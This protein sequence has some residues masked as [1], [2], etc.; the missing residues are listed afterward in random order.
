MK[1]LKKIV[2]VLLTVMIVF[3][4][5]AVIP[6]ASAKTVKK[7]KKPAKFSAKLKSSS[8]LL[9]Y[10]TYVQLSWKK[11]KNAKKYEIYRAK[12]NAKG[13]GSYK[14]LKAV[15]KVKYNDVSINS[16]TYYKYKVR[17][18]NGKVKSKFTA[19]SKKLGY[20]NTPT[21]AVDMNEKCDAIE[22]QWFKIGGATGYK[23]YKST[24]KGKS[25][26]LLKNSKS[27]KE[28][29]GVYTYTDTSVKIGEH[30]YYYITA[31][32]SVMTSKK[33][34]VYRKVFKDY[35]FAVQAGDTTSVNILSVLVAYGDF[36]VESEDES[37]ATCKISEK[38]SGEKELLL[39]GV[40]E[41]YT[42]LK[43]KS[44]QT[45]ANVGRVKVKVTNEPVYDFT[46]KKGES[47]EVY[48]FDSIKSII[49]MYK[50]MGMKIK[51]KISAVSN[52]PEIAKITNP[53]SLNFKIVGVSE[54]E[55]LVKVKLS[56][57]IE[58]NT[59]D[60]LTAKYMVKVE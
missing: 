55:V 23:I 11:V 27:F 18:V 57:E 29:D 58:G 60:V 40:K 17:A 5:A 43:F 38:S 10:G 16:G 30:Y 59:Q 53:G 3:S 21:F 45:T 28:K 34:D 24:D 37:I 32:N 20:M 56:V 47:T 36:D 7:L 33:S 50:S 12:L 13:K 49:D 51:I 52:A 31:Y 9:G 6:T 2:S 25:Y 4:A 19:A 1:N 44:D 46:L 15:K 35:Q 48:D 42:Y 26:K 22:M 39:T 8:A 54:G 41:G 14:K